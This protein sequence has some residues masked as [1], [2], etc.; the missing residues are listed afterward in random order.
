M[1]ALRDPIHVYV[2]ADD[3]EAAVLRT[4]PVQRLR[5]VRQ[6][7]LAHLVFPGAEHSR[8]NHAL[9]AMELAGRV[10]DAL[11]EKAPDLLEPDPRCPERR[12]VRMAALLHDVGHA[13]F[14][15][16]AEELFEDGLSHEDMTVR[17]LRTPEV[18]RALAGAAP[19]GVTT[20]DVERILTGR[21]AESDRLLAQIVSGEL[22]VDKMDYLLRDSLYCG[23][24][25]GNYDLGRLLET[26][27]PLRDP[28][29]RDWGIGIEEGGVHALEALV[30]AR[31]YMFT[32]VYFNVTG[33]V[34]EL[35]LNEWLAGEGMRWPADPERFLGHDDLGV[36]IAM[37]R[38]TSPHARAIVERDHYVL[39]F[40]TREHLTA[41]EREGFTALVEEARARF[42]PGDLLVSN[43]A[44]DPHR[45]GETRVLVRDRDGALEPMNHVSHFI[46]HLTRIER[47]RVYARP[48][49]ADEVRAFLRQRWAHPPE[50]SPISS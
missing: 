14:S 34:L 37:R 48:G 29:T 25:Y 40:E 36:W 4:R 43:S 35:H 22:D 6:L 9:G 11:A 32:Q 20:D 38:S 7:G 26:I 1:L 3:T 23:V 12:R 50:S 49:R 15:H 41:A 31:Y 44:K 13:P 2:R 45:L 16:S 8:F 42:D 27:T 24:R 39:A 17:L 28:A 19:Q 10:Y 47:F 21:G 5:W 18:A 30:L 33:K 46:R